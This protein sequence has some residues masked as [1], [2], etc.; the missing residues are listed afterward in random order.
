MRSEGQYDFSD[1]VW[2]IM[3]LAAD[4]KDFYI[5]IQFWGKKQFQ[6]ENIYINICV[7]IVTFL[8]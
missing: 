5:E 7:G 2:T 8:M 1:V 3:H 6:L 4:V